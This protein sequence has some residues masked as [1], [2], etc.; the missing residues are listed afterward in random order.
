[1]SLLP[2]GHN[3]TVERG[4]EETILRAVGVSKRFGATAALVDVSISIR[5]GSLHA[6][7]GHNGAG[8]STLVKIL[9]GALP[10]DKGDLSFYGMS[11]RHHERAAEAQARAGIVHQDH[12]FAPNLS[13]A[14]AVVLG[15]EP[16]RFGLAF[17][18]RLAR[19]IAR[20]ALGRIG[21]NLDPRERVAALN[22]AERQQCAI[23]RALLRARD[24]LI[25]DEPTSPLDTRE[26]ERLFGVLEGLRSRGTGILLVTHRLEEVT[27][28]CSE[29]TVL[30][31]GRV[32]ADVVGGAPTERDLVTAMLG[33]QLAPN[34]QR[35][36]SRTLDPAWKVA[37]CRRADGVTMELE[38]P[39]RTVTGLFGIPGS[40]RETLMLSLVERSQ[41]WSSELVPPP[42]Q[43]SNRQFGFVP[44]DRARHGIFPNLSVRDNIVVSATG[45]RRRVLRSVRQELQ[46]VAGLI[47]DVSLQGTMS[48]SV[49][50]LS[51]GNQQKILVARAL[52]RRPQLMLLDEPTVGVDVGSC[53]DIY[54]TLYGMASDGAAILV[55][56]QDEEEVMRYADRIYVLRREAIVGPYHPPFDRHALVA[57]AATVGSPDE[58]ESIDTGA[59]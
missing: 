38:I 26:A 2:D 58:P 35:Q 31:G 18:R 32:V 24:L 43:T 27:S 19:S 52:A 17:N 16:R 44:N 40:G 13:V 49:T 54:Q 21:S 23:A 36:R 29:V 20:E 4:S 50:S 34:V 3:N 6:L 9:A 7:V 11:T 51:G 57:L 45:R 59:A 1:M 42:G 33:R 37:A 10:A 41:V 28:K 5:R 8:K 25:L 39:L 53:E 46:C 22:A 47:H 15:S 55:A 56:S 14:E 30:R 12:D 48:D